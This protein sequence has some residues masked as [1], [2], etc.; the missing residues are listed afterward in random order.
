[1]SRTISVPSTPVGEEISV[2]RAPRGDWPELLARQQVAG[3]P[4]R[5]G[6]LRDGMVATKIQIQFSRFRKDPGRHRRLAATFGFV[7]RAFP[8]P[9][10]QLYQAGEAILIP[11]RVISTSNIQ[12]ASGVTVAFS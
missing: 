3:A 2:D 7:Y 10:S 12:P 11:D 8:G 5:V 1:V 6:H 9:L 4:G